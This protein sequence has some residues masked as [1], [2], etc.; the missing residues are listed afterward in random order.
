MGKNKFTV[1]K[2]TCMNCIKKSF[3]FDFRDA[4]FRQLCALHWILEAMA[5]H[6]R[7]GGDNSITMSPITSSWKLK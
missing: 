1:H 7:T 2:L 5:L 6:A 4:F 3:Y